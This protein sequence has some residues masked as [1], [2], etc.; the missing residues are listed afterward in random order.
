MSLLAHI[1]LGIYCGVTDRWFNRNPT[2]STVYSAPPARTQISMQIPSSASRTAVCISC[3]L[4]MEQRK[5]EKI[6]Y[7]EM[8]FLVFTVLKLQS[9]ARFQIE[10]V[11]SKTCH[12]FDGSISPRVFLT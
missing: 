10:A 12:H 5:S 6:R 4:E 2:N 11:I 9:L 7:L 1:R 3:A 8:S